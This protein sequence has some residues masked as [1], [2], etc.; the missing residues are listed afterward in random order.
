MFRDLSASGTGCQTGL[1]SALKQLCPFG[2][3]CSRWIQT[4]RVGLVDL[5]MNGGHSKYSQNG[6][7]WP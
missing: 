6:I 3:R 7:P 5:E 1:N 4:R 2:H